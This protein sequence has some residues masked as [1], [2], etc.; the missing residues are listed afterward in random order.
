MPDG[1]GIL[2]Q[3]LTSF[4]GGVSQGRDIARKRQMEQEALAQEQEQRRFQNQMLEAQRLLQQQKFDY[5]VGRDTA[6][7]T[8]AQGAATLARTQKDAEFQRIVEGLMAQGLPQD[9][10]IAVAQAGSAKSYLDK[11]AETK[12]TAPL[13]GTPEYLRMLREE[14][15][16][17][18]SF[19]PQPQGG[20]GGPTPQSLRAQ[21]TYKKRKETL[22]NLLDAVELYRT[23]LTES[24]IEVLPGEQKA[25]LTGAYANLKLLAK[26]AAE[27]GALTGPDV[28]ILEQMF[29]NP[30][31]K[32]G[33]ALN[34]LQLGGRAKGLLSQLDQYESII[35]GQKARL[36]ENY[37]P[38]WDAKPEAGATQSMADWA[39]A[40]RP[41]PGESQEAYRARYNASVGGR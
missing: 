12:P 36:D 38:E 20:T 25:R 24:G 41:Q 30:A 17:K 28:V 26:D 27:L 19:R 1:L 9:M 40:N 33:A 16:V 10:A 3:A 31:T 13:R 4:G 5:D 35:K 2:G 22:D 34:V 11:P 15:A 29:N 39:K 23:Q 37:N 18:A 7:D 21:A 14:E 6:Q 8:A 32:T